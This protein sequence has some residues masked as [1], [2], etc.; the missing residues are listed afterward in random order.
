MLLRSIAARSRGILQPFP[1][2]P[3]VWPPQSRLKYDRS[4]QP[5]RRRRAI[6]L[7]AAIAESALRKSNG[8]L[9]FTDTT[10]P[11]LPDSLDEI[12]R[13]AKTFMSDARSPGKIKIPNPLR[14][15][16]VNKKRGSEV[17]ATV[18]SSFLIVQLKPLY[19]F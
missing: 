7:G 12:L 6:A 11:V 16:H 13:R 15:T 1:L 9:L 19:R 2:L 14:P 8:V 3:C 5:G 18:S 4:T 17:L 10:K